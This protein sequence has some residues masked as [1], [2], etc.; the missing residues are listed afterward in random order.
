[1]HNFKFMLWLCCQFLR[2][3][4]VTRGPVGDIGLS[5]SCIFLDRDSA[6]LHRLVS[7]T[8]MPLLQLPEPPTLSTLADARRSLE[9][10]RTSVEELNVKIEVAEAALAQIVADSKCAINELLRERAALEDRVFRTMA[11]LSPIR[12]LPNE[13]LREIFMCNFDDYPCCAWV[14][15]AVCSMWRRLA[16]GMPKLWSKVSVLLA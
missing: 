10:A 4:Q 1:M 7:S 8:I 9:S 14:L 5:N 16:L 3:S 15:A 11:Y 2:V 12:R 13:L 6:R